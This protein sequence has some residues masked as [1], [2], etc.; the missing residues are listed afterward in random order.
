MTTT[1]T[2]LRK[3]ANSLVYEPQRQVLGAA[4]TAE[5]RGDLEISVL[6]LAEKIVPA[7]S[8]LS[9]IDEN[10]DAQLAKYR[11]L[12][13]TIEI[14]PSCLDG[15]GYVR[16][17]QLR[18]LGYL[19]APMELTFDEAGLQEDCL[20]LLLESVGEGRAYLRLFLEADQR[21]AAGS[22]PPIATWF[23]TPV[24]WP[25]TLVVTDACV[26]NSDY[27]WLWSHFYL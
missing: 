26:T 10:S 3:L 15:L 27:V 24:S 7:K 4:V 8:L 6:G 14:D 17:S 23:K 20:D 18:E 11:F 9:V 19:S 1:S 25:L 16:P 5:S 21:I 13:L 12:D 2:V 22:D